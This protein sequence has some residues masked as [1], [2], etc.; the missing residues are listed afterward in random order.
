MVIYNLSFVIERLICLFVTQLMMESEGGT[1]LKV[2][3]ITR[4][5]YKVNCEA[6]VEENSHNPLLTIICDLR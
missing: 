3:E 4:L 6:V 1:R 5:H 2:H